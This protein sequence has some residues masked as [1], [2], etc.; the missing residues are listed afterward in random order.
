MSENSEDVLF[1]SGKS[2]YGMPGLL[3]AGSII[4]RMST[5]QRTVTVV[6][7]PKNA[8]DR[9]KSFHHITDLDGQQ[10]LTAATQ[11]KLGS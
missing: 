4:K 7:L 6:E 11:M 5:Q 1:Q 10:Q 8:S 3:D 2:C 9:K